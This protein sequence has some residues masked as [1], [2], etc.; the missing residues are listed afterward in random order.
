MRLSHLLRLRQKTPRERGVTRRRGAGPFC[1]S[2]NRTLSPR[3]PPAE[4]WEQ[5]KRCRA[6]MRGATRAPP[7]EDDVIGCRLI[8][9]LRVDV[10]ICGSLNRRTLWFC[11]RVAFVT[12]STWGAGGRGLFQ[13]LNTAW[14][15]SKYP[16]SFS[17]PHY[18]TA[19]AVKHS[20]I[21]SYFVTLMITVM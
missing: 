1:Q 19:G 5:R 10:S 3:T 15:Q 20:F 16:P 2:G 18:F 4:K 21:N 6:R 13:P 9:A 17:K 11:R 8:S 14:Q 7:G 12:R